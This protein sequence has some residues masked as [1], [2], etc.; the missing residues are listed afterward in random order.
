[1]NPYSKYVYKD[2]LKRERKT[3]GLSMKDMA[4]MLGFKSKVS[5]Y[6]IENGI[7]EPRISHINGISKILGKSAKKFFNFKVQ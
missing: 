6:N 4:Q 5:Y 1:M 7:S 3:K 2:E